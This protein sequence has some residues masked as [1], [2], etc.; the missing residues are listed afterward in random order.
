MKQNVSSGI[1]FLNTPVWMMNWASN[2]KFF[3]NFNESGVCYEMVGPLA[4]VQFLTTDLFPA[5]D[6]GRGTAGWST[7]T[8]RWRCS[9]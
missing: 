9:P 2:E 7:S 6:F 5:T 3:D 4:T 8:C 1:S